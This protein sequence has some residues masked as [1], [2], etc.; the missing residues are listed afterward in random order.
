MAM[1]MV[2]ARDIIPVIRNEGIPVRESCK[3]GRFR[4][5][6]HDDRHPSAFAYR[7]SN[8]FVCFGCG[9]RGDVIDFIMKL[10]GMNFKDSCAYLGIARNR[11]RYGLGQSDD[12]W[13]KKRTLLIAFREWERDY[14]DELTTIYRASHIL[15]KDFRTMEEVE[16]FGD[17]YHE[18]PL[19]EHMMDILLFGS[20]EDKYRLFKEVIVELRSW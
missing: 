17:L 5:P 14:Y 16:R 10:K 13:H 12:R 8:R 15:V 6:F 2:S 9:K 19:I 1:N 3:G 20:D 4:C 7:E 11:G 18:L